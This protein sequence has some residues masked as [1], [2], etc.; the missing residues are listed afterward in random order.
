MSEIIILGAGSYCAAMIDLAQ[1]CGFAPIEIYDDDTS[2]IGETILDTPVKGTITA[3]LEKKTNIEGKNFI[4]AIGDNEIRMKVFDK[5]R[6]NNGI[7]PRLVHPTASISKFAEVGD[8]CYI[9]PQVVIWTKVKVHN[10][11]IISPNVV[12]AHHSNIHRG[13]LISTSASVGANIDIFEGAFLGMS[14]N[15]T[16]GIKSVGENAV[17]GAG[18]VV[19][20]D[21]EANTIFAGVPAKMLRK[22]R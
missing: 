6:A 21:V 9:Q 5:V 13:C 16:T 7:T 3:F 20:S 22:R 19:I 12:I 14:C 18:A 11:C 10:D 15:I 1:E 4:V 8:G 17:I 2:K